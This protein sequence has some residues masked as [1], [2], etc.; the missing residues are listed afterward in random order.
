MGIHSRLVVVK[1]VFLVY[2]ILCGVVLRFLIGFARCR[3]VRWCF[4]Y[5]HIF[6]CD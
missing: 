6:N 5:T 4:Y 2:R 3:L 1:V